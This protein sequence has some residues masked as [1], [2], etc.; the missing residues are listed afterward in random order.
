M[1]EFITQYREYDAF[2]R[3]W[4]AAELDRDGVTLEEARNRGQLDEDETRMVWQLLGRL[5]PG[6]LLVELPEWLA[7][8]KVEF[9]DGATPTAFVGRI[10]Q[11]TEKAVLLAESAAAGPL[12]KLAHEIHHLDDGLVKVDDDDEDRRDWLAR[13]RQEKVQ[14]FEQRIHIPG[15]REAWLPKSQLVHAIRRK[16]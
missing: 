3:A 12:M 16:G 10:E 8:E 11:E 15:L 1:T 9:V 13:Q 7:D 4:H 14:Q 2:A 5:D 6:E